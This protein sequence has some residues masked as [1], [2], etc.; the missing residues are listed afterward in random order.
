M[1]KKFDWCHTDFKQ[2]WC[3]RCGMRI[4]MPNRV[5]L[6]MVSDFMTSFGKMHKKCKPGVKHVEPLVEIEMHRP[7]GQ[8]IKN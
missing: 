2:L 6:P 3:D 1:S 5:P 8:V 7:Q 4:D